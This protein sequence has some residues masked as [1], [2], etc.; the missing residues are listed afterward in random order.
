M[1][2]PFDAGVRRDQRACTT[3][4]DTRAVNGPTFSRRAV[5]GGALATALTAC[6][7]RRANSAPDDAELVLRG[8]ESLVDAVVWNADGSRIFSSS[9]DGTIR[10]WN[11]VTG[12]SEKVWNLRAPKALK[13]KIPGWSTVWSPDRGRAAWVRDERCLTILNLATGEMT[14]AH[15]CAVPIFNLAWSGRKDLLAWLEI[16]NPDK[17]GWRDMES[18]KSG[19]WLLDKND[20]VTALACSPSGDELAAGFSDGRVAVRGR[21]GQGAWVE[22]GRH[23]YPLRPEVAG[24]AW[25]RTGQYI[26]SGGAD[27]TSMAWSRGR[28]WTRVTSVRHD[29]SIQSLAWSPQDDKFATGGPIGWIMLRGTSDT[30]C[31]KI[32]LNFDDKIA[33][34]WQPSV[35]SLAWSPDGRRIACGSADW[36]VRVWKMP[37]AEPAA[38]DK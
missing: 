26:A 16:S 4:H 27:G 32:A 19:Y 1:D 34:T 20:R 8:H 3:D 36:A 29:V 9:W 22:L 11:A 28:T 33:R 24:I 30:A 15:T 38:R 31:S 18:G 37:A 25:S 13:D 7:D 5:L 35:E 23:S 6:S 10:V 14:T 12:R 21:D 2:P 17:I